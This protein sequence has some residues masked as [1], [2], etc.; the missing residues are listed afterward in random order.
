VQTNRGLSQA[1]GMSHGGYKQ[2][3]REFSLEGMLYSFTQH[4]SET[5]NLAVRQ[6]TVLILR[7]GR[8]PRLEGWATSQRVPSFETP[9]CAWLLRM[10]LGYARR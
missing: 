4:T 7:N 2:N 1:P 5:V 9:R 3:G 8:R 10:R 6:H